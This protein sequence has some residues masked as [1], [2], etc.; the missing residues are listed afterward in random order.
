[1]EHGAKETGIFLWS[2]LRQK[3]SQDKKKEEIDPLAGSALSLI[4]HP[5]LSY[6]IL[7]C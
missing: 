2:Q 3:L 7:S 5:S 1:M 6:P 4:G